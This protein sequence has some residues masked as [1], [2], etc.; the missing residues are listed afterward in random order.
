MVS[1]GA[2]AKWQL[3][4][5]RS[6]KAAVRSAL[7][8]P[9]YSASPLTAVFSGDGRIKSAST[10]PAIQAFDGFSRELDIIVP[11]RKINGQP[12]FQVICLK[13]MSLFFLR[14]YEQ[15]ILAVQILFLKFLQ[16][17]QGDLEIARRWRSVIVRTWRNIAI[18]SAQLARVRRVFIQQLVDIL[19]IVSKVFLVVV[20]DQC[21]GVPFR[22]PV[23]HEHHLSKSLDDQTDLLCPRLSKDGIMG[24]RG[25]P[26]FDQHRRQ[27]VIFATNLGADLWFVTNDLKL[28][29]TPLAPTV[30]DILPC[31]V[32]LRGDDHL[33]AGIKQAFYHR[34]S[35]VRSVVVIAG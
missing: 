18:S 24:F 8:E 13:L 35:K 32:I 11:P 4:K 28:K 17:A 29:G 20:G 27:I 23:A 1:D 10:S 19:A 5:Q 30:A 12:V 22:K 21:H 6:G 7:I 2:V 31:F 34:R 3:W 14:A 25:R 9:I 16:I 26:C 33:D 15:T